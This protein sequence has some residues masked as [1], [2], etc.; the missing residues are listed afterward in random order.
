M[1]VKK[2]QQNKQIYQL[3]IYMLRTEFKLITCT[4]PI[5]QV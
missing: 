4:L 3:Y 1:Y 2:Q 5:L